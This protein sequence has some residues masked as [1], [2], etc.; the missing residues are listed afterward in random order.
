M[1]NNN[2]KGFFSSGCI[3][4]SILCKGFSQEDFKDKII[5]NEINL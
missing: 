1:T 3:C 5:N 2:E 4:E